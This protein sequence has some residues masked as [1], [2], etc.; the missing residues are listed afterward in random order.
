MSQLPTIYTVRLD[1]SSEIED[2]FNHWASGKHIA[3][4]LDAGFLSADR[5][6][7]VKGEPKY[8]HIYELPTSDI[9]NSDAYKAIAINDK[10]GTDLVESGTQ[11]ESAALYSQEA[12]MNV[13]VDSN[14][15]SRLTANHIIMIRMEVAPD[16][17]DELIKWHSEEH[18]PI[19]L[20]ASGMLT[21]RLCR[22]TALH[23]S[24]PCNEPEWLSIY[25][26]E[27][28]DTLK[29]SKIKTANETEW[30]K[31]MHSHSTDVQLGILERVPSSS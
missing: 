1:V 20:E 29:D 5:F 7:S 28:P 14:G 8:L 23:P 10:D 9:L 2:E 3:D 12:A 11:N 13:T 18:I 15:L 4:L 22:R 17:A 27:T 25:E 30:A 19:L 31:R 16:A 21:G 26:M 24:V 6:K